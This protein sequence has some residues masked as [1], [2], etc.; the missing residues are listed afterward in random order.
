LFIAVRRINWAVDYLP[1]LA[2]AIACLE[3]K[4]VRLE[5]TCLQ[6]VAD[7]AEGCKQMVEASP[8]GI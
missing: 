2:L 5:N 6:T 3:N 7:A 4:I 8:N 1:L